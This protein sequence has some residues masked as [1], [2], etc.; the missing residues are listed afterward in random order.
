MNRLQELRKSKGLTQ[1]QLAQQSGV[2]VSTLQKIESGFSNIRGIR[3]H[4]AIKLAQALNTT[5]ADL[6]GEEQEEQP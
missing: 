3:L 6:A 4:H 5:V 1:F 2:G